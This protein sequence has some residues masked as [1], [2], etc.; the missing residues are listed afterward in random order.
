MY[1]AVSYP[2]ASRSSLTGND[3]MLPTDRAS[4]RRSPTVAG[5]AAAAIAALVTAGGVT[6]CGSAE[7]LKGG[8]YLGDGGGGS[9][10]DAAPSPDLGTG[11]TGSV[12]AGGAAGGAGGTAPEPAPTCSDGTKNGNETD[13][14]CGGGT[15]PLCGRGQACRAPTDCKNAA[16][17][18]GYCQPAGCTDGLKN[19]NET[20]VDCGGHDCHACADGKVCL[21]G[22][23]CESGMCTNGTCQPATCTDGLKN[24]S[25]TDVDCGGSVCSK[26]PNGLLCT[27][28]GDCQSGVCT[29]TCQSASCSDHILNG[30]ETDTDCG[31]ACS[32]CTDGK[33]CVA[34]GD[35]VS[36]VCDGTCRTPTCTDATRNA[37]ETDVDCGGGTCPACMAGL[38]CAANADCASNV[39]SNGVCQPPSCNDGMLNGNESATDCG[40][41]CARKCDVGQHCNGNADCSSNV[42]SNGACR[43]PWRVQY[44]NGDSDPNNAEAH[45]F[46]QIIN[47]SSQG[48]P[49]SEFKMRY[50][51][52]E[53]TIATQYAVCDYALVG[54]PNVTAAFFTV[55]PARTGCNEYMEVGFTKAAGLLPG[56]TATEEGS[57]GQVQM[58]FFS[59]GYPLY[60]EV[61]DYSYDPS[62]TTYQDWQR[63]TLYH[64][65]TLVWGTEP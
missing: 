62:K 25:E 13:V 57:S 22:P 32:K 29:G 10:P 40:G 36:G 55:S 5:L 41:S 6:G 38:H 39:C 7:A 50:W 64:N 26:C 14:D 45:P 30:S 52:S 35:C 4:T 37:A 20:D 60:T 8:V 21:T 43:P 54:I 1:A 34:P 15:C 9:T 2:A 17:N 23:D 56:A 49:L 16:C 65:G 46:F 31:G 48:V 51:Y 3:S 53:E 61:G 63:V 28:A 18:N 33:M 27:T 24:G 58:R 12:G 47:S 59:Q 42:C 19:G 44:M 11:G